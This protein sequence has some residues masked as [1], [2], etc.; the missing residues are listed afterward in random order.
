MARF[1]RF[2]LAAFAVGS[3][4]ALAACSSNANQSQPCPPP[5][6]C[7][8][9]DPVPPPHGPPCGGCEPKSWSPCKP[10]DCALPCP[11]APVLDPC[12]RFDPCGAPP[13]VYVPPPCEPPA[14]AP[15]DPQQPQGQ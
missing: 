10:F 13:P 11:R 9:C 3:T 12:N 14:P 2:A 5:P 4:L 6:T 1:Q 8:V 15:C 7:H